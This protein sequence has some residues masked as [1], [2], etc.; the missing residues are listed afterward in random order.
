M[1]PKEFA[2]N[3]GVTDL[4]IFLTRIQITPTL[5]KVRVHAEGK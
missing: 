5:S 2:L 4:A 1:P 3:H